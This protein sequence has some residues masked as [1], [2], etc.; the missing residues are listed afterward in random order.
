MIFWVNF[1]QWMRNSG[2]ACCLHQPMETSLLLNPALSLSR[3]HQPMETSLLLHPTLT[4]SL[5]HQPMETSLLLHPALTLRPSHQAADGSKFAVAPNP[6]PQPQPPADGNQL[7]GAPSLDPQP[8]PPAADGSKFAVAPSPDPQPQPPAADG[9][10]FAVAPNPDPQPPA[11]KL[12]VAPDLEPQPGNK[13]AEPSADGN[14]KLVAP[15]PPQP[16][17]PSADVGNKLD[18]EITGGKSLPTL[19]DIQD[20]CCLIRV[21]TVAAIVVLVC[22]NMP[23]PGTSGESE[24]SSH[25]RVLGFSHA[26]ISC[27]QTAQ[28][29]EKETRG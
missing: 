3:S 10:K 11:N 1:A 4:L 14:S 19:T 27:Y 5:S 9:S 16:P 8:Q 21:P 25:Q 7:A 15:Q 13:L 24:G 20:R 26:A 17:Q 18:V 2:E 28:T 12:A 29:R 22:V 6:D 23:S